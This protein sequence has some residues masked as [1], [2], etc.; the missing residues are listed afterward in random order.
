MKVP[1]R[2]NRRNGFRSEGWHQRTAVVRWCYNGFPP[3]QRVVFDKDTAAAV[4]RDQ[5][6]VVQKKG[7]ASASARY[8]GTVGITP[9]STSGT[10]STE[11][12]RQYTWIAPY[13]K[14]IANMLPSGWYSM[15]C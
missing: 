6:T 15:A 2:L 8:R 1:V 7:F 5:S 12:L 3:N 14:H 11:G 9:C 10:L 4:Q 13:V